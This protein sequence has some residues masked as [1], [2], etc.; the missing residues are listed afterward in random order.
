MTRYC[1][2]NDFT[3]LFFFSIYLAGDGIFVMAL[4]NLLH[5]H[6]YSHTKIHIYFIWG[7]IP[8]LYLCCTCVVIVFNQPYRYDISFQKLLVSLYRTYTH[9]RSYTRTHLF[10]LKSPYG[11]NFLLSIKKENL[12]RM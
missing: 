2:Y 4:L 5:R 10:F 3:I 11:R 7:D 1:N 9:T 6:D 8:V 12:T